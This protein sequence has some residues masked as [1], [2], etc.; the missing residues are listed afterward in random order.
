MKTTG[1]I[2]SGVLFIFSGTLLR[3]ALPQQTEV[4][5]TDL[6]Q[7]ELSIPGR[8]VV[9]ARSISRPACC[10]PGTATREEVVYVIEGTVE[11]RIDGRPPVALRAGETLF[12][13]AGAVHSARNVGS[14]NAAELTTYLVETGKPLLVVA[15]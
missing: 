2:V 4:T 12:I 10:Q 3:V 15:K 8:S 14:G 6:Q 5:R 13:P 1:L 11:Y 9:Q 7:H